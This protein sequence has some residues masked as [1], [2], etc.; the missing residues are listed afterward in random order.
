MCE[1]QIPNMKVE[2]SR[3]RIFKRRFW[4]DDKTGESPNFK[5]CKVLRLEIVLALRASAVLLS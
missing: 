2:F 4:M 1:A 3:H 5:K